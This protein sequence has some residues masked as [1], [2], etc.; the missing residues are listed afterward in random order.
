[1]VNRVVTNI[2]KKNKKQKKTKK[3]RKASVDPDEADLNFCWA[4]MSENTFSKV[5]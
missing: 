1:M 2:Q 4:H 5:A 3:K